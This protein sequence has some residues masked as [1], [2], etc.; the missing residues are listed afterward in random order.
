MR[1]FSFILPVRISGLLLSEFLFTYSCYLI[2]TAVIL[3]VGTATYLWDDNGLV[4]ILLVALSVLLGLFVNNLYADTRVDSRVHLVLKM[5]NVAGIA[6]VVQGLLAYLSSGLTLPRWVM[7]LGSLLAFVTLAAWRIFYSHVVLRMI[8][9]KEVLFVGNDR[10][11]EEIAS[12]IRRHP[13]LGFG[14]AGYLDDR[15]DRGMDGISSLGAYLGPSA[16]LASVTE[17]IRPHRIVVAGRDRGSGRLPVGT[18]LKLERNG[19]LIE[20][21]ASTFEAICG[22]VS[23]RDLRASQLIFR[24]DLA[25]RP[26][27]LALQSVYTNL[28]ALLGFLISMPVLILTAIAIKLTSRGPILQPDIRV[29]QHGIPFNLNRFRCCH[30][31]RDGAAEVGEE[32]L[33]LVGR[34]IRKLHLVNLPQVLNLLR[35]EMTL[36]GPRP[37]RPEFVEELSKYFVYYR[38]RHAVKPGMTGWSQ[39]NTSKTGGCADSLTELE[40]DIYYTKHISLALDAYILLHGIRQVLPFAQR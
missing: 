34:W 33:T 22:R 23:S 31:P 9:T 30:I 13:E 25:S 6:L 32:R 35:G 24:D 16:D 10:L 12:R 27:S 11:M 8:G 20:E 2:S 38:Q 15:R 4:R 5:C 39:I 28:A 36:V 29:G 19:T 37:E 14:I 1:I 18:L 26:G 40:Y 3:R 17:R 21:S 7:L